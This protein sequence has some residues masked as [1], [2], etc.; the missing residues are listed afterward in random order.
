ML[1]KET[2]A[3]LGSTRDH[4]GNLYVLNCLTLFLAS[5]PWSTPPVPPSLTLAYYACLVLNRLT[6]IVFAG[7]R[8][9]THLQA[10]EAGNL[11][12]AVRCDTLIARQR[13][14]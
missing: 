8:E 9:P 4:R 12:P 6:D 3:V 1:G 2:F 10:I 13:D 7:S 5:F 14:N 11:S